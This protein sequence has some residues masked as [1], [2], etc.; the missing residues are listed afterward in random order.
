MKREF[1]LEDTSIAKGFAILCLLFYHA[2]ENQEMLV[3]LSVICDP[4]PQNIFLLASSFGNICVAVFVSLTAYGI[5][6]DCMK[7]KTL[8]ASMDKS[9]VRLVRLVQKFLYCYLFIIVIFSDKFNLTGLYGEGKQGFLYGMIDAL[10]FAELFDTPMLNPTWWYME[11][12]I[13]LIVFIPIIAYAYK[14]IGNGLVIIGIL[15]PLIVSLG[16]SVDRYLFIAVL[17]IYVAYNS[18]IKKA[19]NYNINPYIK[20]IGGF[21]IL[22]VCVLVRQNYVVYNTFTYIIDG[23]IA[24]YIIYFSVSI[25]GSIRILRVPLAYIGRYS[26]NIYLIHTFIYMMI[27]QP[28]LYS[29]KYAGIIYLVLV[30]SSLLLAIAMDN[31]IRIVERIVIR[32]IKKIKHRYCN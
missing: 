18:L 20:W 14:Q 17:G 2:F 22:I 29:L 25:L 30:I 3:R 28:Q 10:G 1:T 5:T 13:I 9:M 12:A 8:K 11:L 16:D 21:L 27:Y 24:W 26:M 19:L 7:K 4:I 23:F 31:L 6:L 32:F 15:L